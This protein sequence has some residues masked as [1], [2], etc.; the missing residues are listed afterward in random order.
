VVIDVNAK[1][2]IIMEVESGKV[3]FEKN[4]DK[5]FPPASTTKI[6]TAITVIE[7]LPLLEEITASLK[8]VR[9]EPIVA[10]LKPGVKY[11]A[12]DLL[13]AIL[14]R[15]GNDAAVVLAEGTAGSEEDFARLMNAKAGTL[16][17]KD[18]YFATASGLPTGRKDSQYTTV[19]DLANMMRYALRHE[20]ILEMMS[21]KEAD[22][23]GS[24]RQR[25]HLRTINRSLSREKGT[26]W[27]KTGYT[28]EAK[29]TFVGVDPCSEPRIV[30]ALLQSTDLWNDIAALKDQGLEIYEESRRTI[31]SGIVDWIRSRAE[32]ILK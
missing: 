32:R 14:I 28:R 8:A 27:G 15:S 31:V 12:G 11:R 3:L 4:A 19:R 20:I 22:I 6:M 1:S 17:L 30:F 26:A 9:V 29:R 21:R 23:Y 13:A 10:G 25:I 16:G 24:D 7:C 18:T 5:R 2:A